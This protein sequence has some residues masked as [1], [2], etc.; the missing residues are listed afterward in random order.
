MIVVKP[1]L[2]SLEWRSQCK[3]ISLS[4][5][6]K[7]LSESSSVVVYLYERRAFMTIRDQ[8]K[9]ISYFYTFE[10]IWKN[11]HHT[12]SERSGRCSCWVCGWRRQYNR[13]TD[14]DLFN[15]VLE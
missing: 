12:M 1:I 7:L 3:F 8:H 14:P 10:S 2:A 5:L 4:H 9:V 6:L 15:K 11:A 13:Y